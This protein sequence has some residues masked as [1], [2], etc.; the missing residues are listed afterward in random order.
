MR[1][2]ARVTNADRVIE[3]SLQAVL[4]EPARVTHLVAPDEEDG[5]DFSEDAE[6][7]DIGG[8]EPSQ[9]DGS[10]SR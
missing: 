6:E 1:Q 7:P 8:A 4:S 9:R 3:E 10:S 5:N 2:H